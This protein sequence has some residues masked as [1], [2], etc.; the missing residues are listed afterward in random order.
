MRHEGLPDL[1]D[2]IEYMKKESKIS[3]DP[4]CDRNGNLYRPKPKIH[5]FVNGKWVEID[6]FNMKIKE[7]S[8]NGN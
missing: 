8:K 1:P 5:G 3:G 2:E 6:L 4:E 7:K